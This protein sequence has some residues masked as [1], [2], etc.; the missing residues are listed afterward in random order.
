MS[1]VSRTQESV[2]FPSTESEAG[3]FSI[4]TLKAL[5]RWFS[6]NGWATSYNP[7]RIPDSFRG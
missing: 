7:V 4:E 6:C 5:Q 1:P 2:M 3:V